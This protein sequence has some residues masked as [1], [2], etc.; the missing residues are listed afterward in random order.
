MDLSNQLML[1][2]SL[3]LFVSI[4]ASRVSSRIGAPMLLVFLILGVLAGVGGPGGIHFSSIP[5]AHFIGSLALG[6]ILFDGGLRTHIRDFHVGLKPALSLSTLGVLVTTALTGLAAVFAL[7]LQIM[8][9]ML[10]GAMVASTDAAAVFSLLHQNR[11]ELKQR[12]AATLE[13]ESGSNDPMAV[14]LVLALIASLQLGH[15]P[16]VLMIVKGFFWQMGIGALTGLLGGRFLLA[17]LNHIELHSSLYPLLALSGGVLIFSGTTLI[18]GSGFLAIYLAGLVLGNHPL[19]AQNNILRM[20]DGFAWLSQIILFIMLGLLVQPSALVPIAP[21]ALLVSFVLIFVARP[22][23]V[24]LCLL[25]FRFPFREQAFISW[26]GLRGAVP[27]VLATFPMLA[28][29][30]RAEL[31][32]NVAFFVVLVSLV[33]QGWTTAYAARQLHVEVPPQPKPEHIIDIG[34]SQAEGFEMVG[35]ALKLDSL[36]VNQNVQHLPLP[37]DTRVIF[38]IR[39]QH[40]CMLKEIDSLAVGDYVLLLSRPEHLAA[41]NRLFAVSDAPPRLEEHEFFGDFV[42]N[43][44][45]KLG[46]V[47]LL[48]GFRVVKDDE[49]M[50]LA[51]YISRSFKGRAVVGDSIFLRQVELIVREMANSMPTKI[52]VKIRHD[53]EI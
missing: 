32:F 29:L 19:K 37:G 31:Y 5:V 4:I 10:L 42:L 30:D 26:V 41:L 25:P 46:D 35:Y 18:N 27:I 9:G 33:L 28:G 51:K 24:F 52:G 53:E 20:H 12:V 45:A 16:T 11:L 17:L 39:E 48:Y 1:M 2:V 15:P 3:L 14:F 50:T 36:A 21:G 40:I 44:E 13:I 47:G 43:G 8:Q 7:H 22:L 6:I 49:N 23:A 34:I 38:I